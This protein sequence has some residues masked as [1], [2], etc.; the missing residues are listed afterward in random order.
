[1]NWIMRSLFGS[2][3]DEGFEWTSCLLLFY[4][5]KKLVLDSGFVILGDLPPHFFSYYCNFS[6][7]IVRDNTLY[8]LYKDGITK[9]I[10]PSKVHLH[11][12]KGETIFDIDLKN[13]NYWNLFFSSPT[14]KIYK[15][16]SSSL[17]LEKIRL[18]DVRGKYKIKKAEKISKIEHPLFERKQIYGEKM[19]QGIFSKINIELI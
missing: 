16:I 17:T 19:E 8:Y 18:I 2:E 6:N 1:M 9:K 14:N 3:R 7:F 13:C 12:K 15:S 4:D 11:I 10:D 5:R